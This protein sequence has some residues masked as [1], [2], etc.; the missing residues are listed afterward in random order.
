M[1]TD[2]Q[3]AAESLES[4]RRALAVVAADRPTPEQIAEWNTADKEMA[5][6]IRAALPGVPLHH[7]YAVLQASRVT[8]RLDVAA[9]P[10]AVPPTDRAAVLTEAERTMLTYALDQAQE[11][12]WSEDGFTDEDQAA[13]DSLRQLATGTPQPETQATAE[14]WLTDSARIGRTLIWSWSDVGKGAFREG[15]RAAQAEARALLGGERGTDQQQPAVTLPGKEAKIPCATA[16]WSRTPHAPHDWQ[17]QP[18]MNPVHCP[19]V[20]AVSTEDPQ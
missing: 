10:A 6:R 7:A 11:K 12:I 9:A 15:Y 16:F 14:P 1:S 20:A 3:T 4:I 17:Q 8:Q 13:V 18:G 2:P 19:G 5:Q